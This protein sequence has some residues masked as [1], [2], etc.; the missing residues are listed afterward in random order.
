MGIHDEVGKSVIY[1]PHHEG[2]YIIAKR[3]HEEINSAL[4]TS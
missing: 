4:P 3:L 2:A 1:Y